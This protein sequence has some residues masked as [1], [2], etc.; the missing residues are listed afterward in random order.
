MAEM[1]IEGLPVLHVTQEELKAA[2][3]TMA[4]LSSVDDMLCAGAGAFAALKAIADQYDLTP[5]KKEADV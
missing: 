5:K 1:H 4:V 2:A 3:K